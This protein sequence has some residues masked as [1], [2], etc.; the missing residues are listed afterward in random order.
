MFQRRIPPLIPKRETLRI[1]LVRQNK[2][3]VGFWLAEPE[4][5]AH[6]PGPVEE[7]DSRLQRINAPLVILGSSLLA[8][9][10]GV[11]RALASEVYVS[12]FP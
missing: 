6:A 7:T 5:N 8:S 2:I 3:F 1:Q 11:M 10:K 12:L 4:R 9:N